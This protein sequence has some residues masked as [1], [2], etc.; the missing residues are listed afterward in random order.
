MISKEDNYKLYLF[1]NLYNDEII[2]SKISDFR[3]T[4]YREIV[5]GKRYLEQ[6]NVM[7]GPISDV[8]IRHVLNKEYDMPENSYSLIGSSD[9]LPFYHIQSISNVEPNG[10][11]ISFQDIL[12]NKV[13]FEK[14]LYLFLG[15]YCIMN[16]TMVISKEMIIYFIPNEPSSQYET[17]TDIIQNT[18]EWNLMWKNKCNMYAGI[19]QRHLLF[20]GNRI[21][22]SSLTKKAMFHTIPQNS[23]TLYISR[24]DLDIT[25]A[26]HL[27]YIE[28][29]GNPY[30]LVSDKFINN[31]YYTLN[32]V[33]YWIVNDHDG[34]GAGYYTFSEELPIFQIPFKENPIPSQNIMVWKYDVESDCLLHPIKHN[35]PMQYPNIYDFSELRSYGSIFIELLEPTNDVCNFYSYIHSYYECYGNQYV[36]MLVNETADPKIVSYNPDKLYEFTP[37]DYMKSMFRGDLR[38]WILDK[39]INIMTD[40]PSFYDRLYHVIYQTIKMT[41]YIS[42]TFDKDK[43]IY[44]KT[45]RTTA[46][47][48][49]NESEYITT[50]AEDMTVIHIYNPSCH[51]RHCSLFI[52]GV[53]KS[54]PHVMYYCHD[55]FIYFPKRYIQNNENIEIIIGAYNYID[56]NISFDNYIANEIIDF[57]DYHVFDYHVLEDLYYVFDDGMI[58]NEN[59]LNYLVS[60]K[61]LQITFTDNGEV[62]DLEFFSGDN[63]K[64]A[65]VFGTLIKPTDYTYFI[66]RS[67]ETFPI[68]DIKGMMK[69]FKLDSFQVYIDDQVHSHHALTIRSTDFYE[70]YSVTMA[71]GSENK[72]ILS[73][74][75]GKHEKS[76]FHIYCDGLLISPSEYEIEFTPYYNHDVTIHIDKKGEFLIEYIGYNEIV[77]YDGP[78]SDVYKDGILYLDMFD[79]FPYNHLMSKIYI[80]GYFIHHNN[81][82]YICQNNML[83]VDGITITDESHLVILTQQ[84]DS[85]PYQ[86]NPSKLFL[87]DI[88]K[89]DQVYR[90]Y[91]KENNLI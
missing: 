38:A 85:D 31:V 9:M 6:N 69:Q 18:T 57:S 7:T 40:V 60:L 34:T 50:F 19:T 45:Y 71:E 10:I 24:G 41:N 27:E 66:L 86:Y 54:I 59:A 78:I 75:R 52:N 12:E 90:E 25:Q 28:N 5:D 73:N 76:R 15:D 84:M 81:L 58:A 68:N 42:Y 35:I 67:E 3:T 39:I 49:D 65:S 77:T 70:T 33:K 20:E 2:S 1:N 14:N 64:L 61:K 44:Q 89:T 30:F 72:I 23:W 22:L 62:D 32:L 46:D 79:S 87:S 8:K 51:K 88:A 4:L 13:K 91:I 63:I 36:S 82:H 56:E 17:I 80:D 26:T 43:E 55:I 21:Y 16:V 29:D 53:Y 83:K 48:C 37:D 74:F 47:H 11:V